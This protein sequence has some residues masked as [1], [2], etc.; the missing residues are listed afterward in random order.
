MGL[1]AHV[2]RGVA[3]MVTDAALGGFR[4]FPRRVEDLDAEALSRVMG[5]E[6]SSISI[7][8]GA[9]GTS[10]RARL[11][12][13]GNDVPDSVFVK[14]SATAAATR[15]LGELARLGETEARFYKQLAAEIG[16]AVPRSY[17]SD[18]DSLTGRYVIVLE[19]MATSPCEFPDTLNPLDNDKMAL[20]VEALASVHGTFWGRLP[21]KAGGG[22]QFGWLWSPSADPTVSLTPLVVRLSARRLADRTPIPVDTGRFV[23][24]NFQAV[25]ALVDKG[26]HTVLHGDSH[27]GNTFFRNGRAGLLDWQVVRRGH[28]ARDLSYTLVLGMATADRQAIERDLLDVYRQAFAASAGTDLDGDELWTRY[29]QAV[30]YAFVAP[31]TTAGL[32]GMQTEEIAFEGLRRAVAALDDLETVAALRNAL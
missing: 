17:G 19:D 32:G 16:P 1:A 11:S 5:R 10:S 12:L 23:W 9:K 31:L 27:P 14:M 29:R 8:D 22:G 24:E 6:V 30:A 21:E 25:T 4:D 15:M 28:P 3:R 7:L 20:L 2:G 18:W 26:Q 13:R